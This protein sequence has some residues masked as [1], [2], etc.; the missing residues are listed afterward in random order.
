MTETALVFVGDRHLALVDVDDL[1]LVAGLNW[2]A[3]LEANGAV[4]AV[5]KIDGRGVSMHRRIAGTPSGMVTDHRNMNTLDNRRAN[6]RVATYSQN[7]CNT[8]AR[9]DNKVG[10]KGVSLVRHSGRWRAVIGVDGR[11]MHL[12]VFDSPEEA[13][14]AYDAAASRLYGE[15]ARLNFPAG[16]AA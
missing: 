1:P 15:F 3:Q 14:R 10:L 11:Q 8:P 12:G 2:I 6:L 7:R 9:A 5:T 4:Y 13:A 16:A